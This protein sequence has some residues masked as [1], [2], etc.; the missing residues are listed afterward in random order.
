MVSELE[1][2]KGLGHSVRKHMLRRAVLAEDSTEAHLFA[3]EVQFY[4]NMFVALIH[5]L[6]RGQSH[7][8]LVVHLDC[9][10]GRKRLGEQGRES[11]A[12]PDGIL[13]GVKPHLVLGI[14]RGG[15]N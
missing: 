7:G 15:G 13:G 4:R 10:D 12:K 14:A 2:R 9:D 1:T 11:T 6:C 8:T 5:M 3:K